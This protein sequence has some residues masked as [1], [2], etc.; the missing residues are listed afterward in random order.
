MSALAAKLN[1]MSAEMSDKQHD[2]VRA[3][4]KGKSVDQLVGHLVA[5]IDEVNVEAKAR[6]LN[7]GVADLSDQQL[8]AAEQALIKEAVKPFYDPA[9]RNLLLQIKQDNE[10]TIDRVS[11]DEVLAAGYS[12]AAL[13]KA[14]AKIDSF[15][16]FIEDNK[17]ELTVLQV[18]Y[19][20][21][22]PDRLRFR[23]LK[24]IAEQIARPPVSATTEE[25]W[26]CYEAL[27][28]AKIQ[29][30]GGQI[31][32]DL[33]SLIGH[34]LRPSE[35]LTPFAEVVRQ[36]YAAWRAEQA[37]AGAAFTPE[38]EMW[39]DKIAEHIATSLTIEMEDFHDGWFAQR[40]DLGKAHELF[41]D[42]LETIVTDMNRALTA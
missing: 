3:H 1:R 23:D 9:L 30:R 21:A 27:E 31:I 16:K 14:R 15:R 29:G 19:G 41:G 38:Q 26:R 7:P 25:L 32:T 12:Q 10:Q 37:A 36:R 2:E 40:G 8:E 13:D 6:E 33:V 24:K 39:L 28:A 4:A 5:S 11:Q 18:F 42:R 17:D 20:Q 35:P 34:T 22:T